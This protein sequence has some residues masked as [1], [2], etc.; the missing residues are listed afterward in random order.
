[1]ADK[2]LKK[3]KKNPLAVISIGVSL[4]LSTSIPFL[5]YHNDT[6]IDSKQTAILITLFWALLIIFLVHLLIG[7]HIREIIKPQYNSSVRIAILI[8]ISHREEYQNED[9]KLMV[10]GFGEGISDFVFKTTK[11]LSDNYEFVL[12]DNTDFGTALNEIKKELSL[13]TKYFISTLSSFST[14]FA[15]V[16]QD[17][18][19]DAILINTISGSTNIEEIENRVYNF[20]PTS[21]REINAILECAEKR[22]LKHP[23]IYNFRSTFPHECRNFFIQEWNRNNAKDIHI[24]VEEDTYEFI[25]QSNFDPS[26]PNFINEKVINSDFIL[27]F[28]YGNSFYDLIRSL[29]THCSNLDEKVIYT[30]STFKY[31]EWKLNEKKT[32]EDL[33][34][35]TVRPKMKRDKFRTDKDVVKY[36]AEQTLDR[37]LNTLER[38][39]RNKKIKFDKAWE[40]SY[41]KRLDLDNKRHVKVETV[42]I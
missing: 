5:I 26:H 29:R 16:F 37:L 41:P 19:K 17:L 22:S 28:G 30:I 35:I 27:I 7:K 42:E 34:V 39:N 33:N 1:M 38:I 10:E 36:F 18:S 12:I 32:V 2:L 3:A 9:L 24:N 21:K 14:K 31:R 13:G 11:Y 20:Y 8:P 40:S 15:K 25:S 23:F 4:W 6:F